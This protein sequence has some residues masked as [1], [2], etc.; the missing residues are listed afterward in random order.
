[1]ND[2]PG[3]SPAS[4]SDEANAFYEQN[5]FSRLEGTGAEYVAAFWTTLAAARRDSFDPCGNLD[6]PVVTAAFPG[7]P[8]HLPVN[9]LVL[10][11][12]MMDYCLIQIAPGKGFPEHVHGYGEE[13]YLVLAGS[14]KVRLDGALHDAKPRDFFHILPGVPHELFNPRDAEE[15]FEVFVVNVPAVHHDLRSRYWAVPTGRPNS[16]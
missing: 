11:E 14:G 13:F 3:S 1:M 7:C 5:G 9:F 16:R 4:A 15:V 10:P 12:R 2:A 6:V 8:T